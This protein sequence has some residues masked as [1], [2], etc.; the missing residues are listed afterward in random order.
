[1]KWSREWQMVFNT[2]KCTVMHIG[3]RNQ[4]GK[5]YYMES[6]KLQECHEEK[7]LGVLVS[8]DLKVGSQ[9]N[10]AF[11]KAN[12]MLGILKRNIVNKTPLIMLNLYK[13]LVRPHV[14]YCVSTWSPHY[15]KDK[16]TLEHIQHR[17]T[18]LIPQ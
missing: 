12:W 4:R 13:T 18:T 11:S 17:F 3:N 5:T 16:N 2:D 8:D 15:V 1:M 10:Q 9:C 7:D 6:H 14:E